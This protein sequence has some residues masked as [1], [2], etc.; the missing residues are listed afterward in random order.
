MVVTIPSSITDI[1]YEGSLKFDETAR[2]APPAQEVAEWD[3]PQIMIGRPQWWNIADV[4][5]T[6]SP[7]LLPTLNPCLRDRDCF[8]VQFSCAF[9]PGRD[10]QLDW[11]RFSV[12]LRSTNQGAPN[13]IAFDLYPL[14]VYE[15]RRHVHIAVLPTLTFSET[16]AMVGESI[17]QLQYGDLLP[18]TTAV[19]VREPNFSWDMET[20]QAPPLRGGRWFHALV[21]CPRDAQGVSAEVELVTDVITPGGVFRAAVRRA[22]TE[23]LCCLI[24]S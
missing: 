7:A 8:L 3:K 11:A 16:K 12:R 10:T 15:T 2:N 21:G 19:G 1:L 5:R 13:A 22:D 17:L 4:Y 20:L 24:C 6:E 18:L 14:E 23:R 9:R